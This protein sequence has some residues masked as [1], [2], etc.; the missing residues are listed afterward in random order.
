MASERTGYDAGLHF[1]GTGSDWYTS[2]SITFSFSPRGIDVELVTT[3]VESYRSDKQARRRYSQL[4]TV[5]VVLVYTA[6][7][8]RL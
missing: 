5:F 6:S 2:L 4:Q 3:L 1:Y 7:P 8:L